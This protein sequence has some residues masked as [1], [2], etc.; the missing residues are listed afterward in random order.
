MSGD[1]SVHEALSA[2]LKHLAYGTSFTV[3]E[4]GADGGSVWK[5]ARDDIGTPTAERSAFPEL[6]DDDLDAFYAREVRHLL[7]DRLALIACTSTDDPTDLRTFLCERHSAVA[8]TCKTPLKA[9]LRQVIKDSPLTV[10]YE[11]VVFRQ[12]PAGESDA[13]QL[14]LHS[15]PLFPRGASS[16]YPKEIQV[17]F[18]P[19]DEHGTV[20]AVVTRIPVADGSVSDRPFR[21]IEIQ[22]GTVP[23]GV[24]RLTAWLVAPGHTQFELAGVT[25]GLKPETRPWRQI[26][27]LVPD[28]LASPDPVH[29]ICA[30]E[31]SVD[32]QR[33]RHRISRLEEVITA[34][35]TGGRPLNVSVVA[36]GAHSVEPTIKEE[37][38]AVLAWSATTDRAIRAL[39]GL[40]GRGPRQHEY[41]RAAQLEC[42]LHEIADKLGAAEGRTALVT[43]GARPPHPPAVDLRTEIIPCRRRLNWRSEL[44]QLR[45]KASRLTFGALCDKGARGEIWRYLGRDAFEEVEAL[46]ATAFVER[47]GLREPMQAIPFPLIDQK[48]N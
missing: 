10:P 48:G 28:R 44:D 2:E 19:T 5:V 11:L 29:L 35:D 13:G 36:Y 7:G 41:P 32:A 31:V 18:A 14:K 37:P 45:K 6:T 15:H 33:D 24:H 22:S 3:V 4:F 9:L 27:S 25:L 46:D 17:R 34:A 20:F 12:A 16:G 1:E 38:V 26:T 30:I 39:R 23:P 21:R 40:R 42:V 43:I 47:L 8:F